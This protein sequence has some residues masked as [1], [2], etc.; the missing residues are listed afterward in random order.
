MTMLRR[1][2]CIVNPD[3][4]GQAAAPFACPSETRCEHA[5]CATAHLS[6]VAHQVRSSQ[7]GTVP[8]LLW[9]VEFVTL[10]M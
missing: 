3:A 7:Y 9:Q 8:S 5:T 1:T 4:I 10:L 6:G 2:L